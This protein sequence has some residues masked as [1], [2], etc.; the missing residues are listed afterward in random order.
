MHVEKIPG[1]QWHCN[2][3]GTCN[4]LAIW[5]NEGTTVKC[6]F[7]GKKEVVSSVDI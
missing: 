4:K 2:Q 3:C 7:C 6:K 5:P 1:W